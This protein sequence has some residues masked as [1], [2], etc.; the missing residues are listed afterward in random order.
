MTVKDPKRGGWEVTVAPKA[1]PK[2]A[3]FGEVFDLVSRKKSFWLLAFG[4]AASSICG[5]ADIVERLG[6]PQETPPEEIPARLKKDKFVF[7]FAPRFHPAFRHLATIRKD[8]GMRTIFNL[9]GPLLNPA[10]PTHIVLGVARPDLLPLMAE[11]LRDTTVRRAAIVHGAGG[12]DEITPMGRSQ[13]IL[14]KDG[15]TSEAEIDPADYGMASCAEADLRV[16]SPEHAEKVMRELLA[17]RGPKAMQDML[18]L[19]LGVAL[20]LLN[21]GMA[22]PAAI[23]KARE[24]VMGGVGGRIIHA[25]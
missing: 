5:S 25:S 21:D 7:L 16:T 20:T 22:M 4:A 18:I 9:L 3:A 24:A 17:G 14:L 10:R 11:A 19:N 13:M 12:Y 8:L 23:G 2:A 6:L 15:A 1:K